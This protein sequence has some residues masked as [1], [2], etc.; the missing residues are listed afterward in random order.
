MHVRGYQEEG[1]TTTPFDMVMLNGLPLHLVMDVIDA[2]GARP[3]RRRR[4]QLMA[5]ERLRMRR[6]NARHG[7]EDPRSPGG[8]VRPRSR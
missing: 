8:A 7:E 6:Y 2:S 1:T 4:G 5:D 3:A